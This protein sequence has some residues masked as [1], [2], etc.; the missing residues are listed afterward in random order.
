MENCW[1][2]LKQTHYPAPDADS[3]RKGKPTGPISL[4]HIIR[5]LKHLDQV[6]NAESIE[7]F[8]RAMQIWQTRMV[9]FKWSQAEEQATAVEAGVAIPIVVAAG[10]TVG[11]HPGFAFRQSVKKEHLKRNHFGG[12]L[13]TV[14]KTSKSWSDLF[15]YCNPEW[16]GIRPNPYDFSIEIL[17]KPTESSETTTPSAASLGPQPEDIIFDETHFLDTLNR[18]QGS[19]L[20]F[21]W[22]PIQ[23]EFQ[24][25][26]ND[27]GSLAGEWGSVKSNE[28]E[29]GTASTHRIVD[30]NPDIDQKVGTPVLVLD[31]PLKVTE[32]E[33]WGKR[34]NLFVC[35]PLE[36]ANSS[37]IEQPGPKIFTF[38]DFTE[39]RSGF[40]PWMKSQF[41]DP[42]FSW[43]EM[44]LFNPPEKEPLQSLEEVVKNIEYTLLHH[45]SSQAG[46]YLLVKDDILSHPQPNAIAQ[47]RRVE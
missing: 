46:L 41:V 33:T 30:L 12:A 34:Y 11:A 2:V 20:R 28:G 47:H 43:D 16:Q 14:I 44:L 26:Y 38:N 31:E 39:F 4:G 1:F 40:E 36:G 10:L 6:I 25:S 35:R 24:I 13:P 29:I 18:L 22:S 19:T 23:E 15:A 5:D 3:M 42:L 17:P 32:Q 27:T 37:S 45:R 9:D 21:Y 8:T 7:P